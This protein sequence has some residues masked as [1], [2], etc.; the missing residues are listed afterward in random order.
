MSKGFQGAL[1]RGLGAKEHLLTVTGTQWR[2]SNLL[3]VHFHTD[4]ML[5][6]DGEAPAAW[7]RAWFPDPDGGTKQ[8]QRGYTFIDPDPAAGTLSVDFVIHHPLGPAS[9]WARNC[10]PGDTIEA[11]RYGETDFALLDP[12]P[13]GYLFLGDLAA[14]PAISQLVAA[15][16]QDIP[17]V[18]YLEKHSEAD[19]ESPLPEGPNVTASWVEPLSD[20]QALAQAI[21]GG[22]RQDWSNWYAW[23]TAEATATRHARTVLQREFTLNRATLHAQG[24]W[25]QGRAMGKSRVLEEA[26]GRADGHPGG[27]AAG[28]GGADS[29]GNTDAEP[30]TPTAGVLAPARTALIIAGVFQALLSI[31]GIVPFI[32]FAELCREFIKGTS[33]EEVM[34]TGIAAA[35]VMAV[36]ALG[37]TLLMLAMHLYDAR[38]STALRRRLMDKLSRLPLGWF[39]TRQSSDVRKLVA[40][41][42]AGM[43]YLVTH[44]VPDLVGALVAPVAALIYLFTVDC[45]LALVLLL[46]IVTFIVVMV[47]IQRRE[48]DRVVVSQRNVSRVT[49]QAQT[50]IAQRDVSRVF[51][52]KSIVDLPA[53]L[54]KVGTFVDSLQRDT[55]PSKIIAV[56][57]NRPTTVLGL[58]V[59][60]T[61]LLMM[62]G[63]VSVHDAIPFL[64]LGPSFGAQLVAI[65]G[66]IGALLVS[67][68]GRAGL[69]LAVSTPELPGPADRPAPQGHVVFDGVRFGY[70]PDRDVLPSFSLTLKAGSL[71]AVVGAS[72][73][74][75]STVGALLARL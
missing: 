1:L 29:A 57:I 26:D 48:R 71:T 52:E 51:G 43:H 73:A 46:P 53:T 16:P 7:M 56:M 66:G 36:S 64:I 50:F 67:L 3:R 58:L 60:A 30:T 37:T 35:V 69:A 14:Y 45:R 8:F 32:L 54:R 23:V 59:V 13:A 34:G 5:Q 44:A 11:T 61:W 63:W 39:T 17:V 42:V 4:T 68:D 20:G 27:E 65:S 47:G 21:S 18:V 12:A 40:D 55:G 38:Y 22:D 75:K 15:I 72:G 49:G 19:A 41:D 10:S 70:S 24:Y 62:P 33:R 25:V 9:W 6:A 74:G 2:T 31:V 28:H